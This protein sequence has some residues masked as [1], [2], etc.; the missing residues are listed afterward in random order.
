V[1]MAP[2]IVGLSELDGRRFGVIAAKA[3]DLRYQDIPAVMEF[4]KSRG[5]E[6]LIT[7]CSTADMKAAQEMERLG[8]FLTDTLL[9]FSYDLRKKP[10]P[11]RL[12]GV[13]IR[14]VLPGEA[15]SVR[16]A[17]SLIF[18]GYPGHY[19]MDPLLDPATCD[20]VYSDWAYRLCLSP[21]TA[22]GVLLA[23]RG[24]EVLG[25][26]SMRVNSPEEGEGL[27]FGVTPANRGA[28]IYREIMVECLKWCAH[29]NIGR[30]IIST[31]VTNLASQK[32]WVRLGF[33]PSG[34]FY[35]YH[36]WFRRT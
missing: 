11:S 27:L 3:M 14:P 33:E 16:S 15:D 20:E 28:G 35:T 24:E 9:Y 5:V 18:P 34:S 36:K 31:Q 23:V 29:H 19:H 25:F 1:I 10:L 30:M 32:T 2:D 7:R 12:T 8:F 6:F 13:L 26:G 17:T 22:G 4:C 21:E